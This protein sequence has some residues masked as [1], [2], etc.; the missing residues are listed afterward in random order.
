VVVEPWNAQLRE[1]SPAEAV[2]KVKLALDFS[3]RAAGIPV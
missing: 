1:T 2:E 3:L